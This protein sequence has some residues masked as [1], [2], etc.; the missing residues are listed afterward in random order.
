MGVSVRFEHGEQRQRRNGEKK[1]ESQGRHTCTKK[2]TERVIFYKR[3]E[4][5]QNRIRCV[6][7]LN[8]INIF[9]YISYVKIRYCVLTRTGVP[10]NPAIFSHHPI[11]IEQNPLTL[12]FSGIF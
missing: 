4:I 10:K 1:K 12:F 3:R 11:R 9:E 6:G 5:N 2:E 7:L 8:K